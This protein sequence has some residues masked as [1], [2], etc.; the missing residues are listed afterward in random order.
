VTVALLFI[1]AAL[2]VGDWIA[3]QFRFFRVEYVLKPATMVVLIAAAAGADLGGPKPWVVAALVFGLLGDVGLMLSRE[4]RTDRP[5]II[6]LAAFLVG[7]LCYQVAYVVSGI[8][9]AES[10]AGLLIVG[11]VSALVLPDV[12]RAVRRSAGPEF[13]VVVGGYSA[14]LAV[15]AV[16]AIG[17]SIIPTALGGVLFLASDTLIARNR[18]VTP[19]RF[20]PLLVIV[21]Y[22]L[23][24]FLIVIGLIRSF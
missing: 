18:F 4:G 20:G 17:T 23:A 9:G 8:H 10:I 1:A 24:Q 7:H 22:H 15:M 2:A 6:G 12:L 11:G 3:V 14:V 5:F 13:A 19:V 21:T 16:L